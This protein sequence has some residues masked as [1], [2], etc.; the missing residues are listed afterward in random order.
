MRISI[1]NNFSDVPWGRYPTDGDVCGQN[2]RETHLRRALQDTNETVI[3]DLDG[4]EGL[5]SSFLDE[6]FAGLVRQGYFTEAEL[7]SRLEIV[8]TQ[9]EFRMYVDLAWRYIQQAQSKLDRRLVR[10]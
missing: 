5:G 2:F 3:V 8:T 6:A 4:V 9:P 1:A 7:K 10:A